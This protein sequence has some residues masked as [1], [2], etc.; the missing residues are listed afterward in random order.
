MCSYKEYRL[1]WWRGGRCAR[2]SGNSDGPAFSLR[3]CPWSRITIVEI[4]S[5]LGIFLFEEEEEKYAID[6]YYYETRS[7]CLVRG[8]MLRGIYTLADRDKVRA[9]KTT[10]LLTNIK[11]DLSLKHFF[12]PNFN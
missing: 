6:L 1:G 11:T 7:P 4:Q 3:S 8:S 9:K 2:D 12:T 5:V 10:K